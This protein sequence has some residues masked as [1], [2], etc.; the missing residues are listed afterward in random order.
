MNHDAEQLLGAYALAALDSE[1]L[2]AVERHLESCSS[3][4]Q[5]LAEYRQ[6]AHGL[7]HL[8]ADEAPDPALRV[9]LAQAVVPADESE[10]AG[11]DPDKALTVEKRTGGWR[12]PQAAWAGL[13]L[14]VVAI[15]LVLFTQLRALSART[16]R[17]LAQEQAN[18][19]A[20]AVLTYPSSRIANLEQE[21]VRGSFIYD[22]TLTLGVL[23]VWG[24]EPLDVDQTYQLWLVDE[25]GERSS[26]GLL[27]PRERSAFVSLVVWSPV[28]FELIQSI[29]LTIEP[30]GG[31]PSPTGP[32]VLGTDLVHSP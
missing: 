22:E 31:S 3:C 6:V 24:L 21:S 11:A 18:Q 30:T 2:E 12:W 19:T 1:E 25:Q 28:E 29:G 27:S 8:T 32:R 16:E 20:L 15:N 5:M 17:L 23:N 9:R 26:A 14:A 10:A 13:G 4:R 7:L